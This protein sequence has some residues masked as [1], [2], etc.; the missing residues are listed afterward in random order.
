MKNSIGEKIPSWYR[1]DNSAKIYPAT[2]SK[3]RSNVFRL[4]VVLKEVVDPEVLSQALGTVIT[5]F[6]GFS[7]RIR[8]G[9]FWYYLEHNP[10]IPEVGLDTATP[11]IQMSWDENNGFLFRVLYYSRTISLECFHSIT[12]GVGGM[13][14]LKALCAQYLRFKGY[15]IEKDH[16]II[17]IDT[18][19]IMEEIQD[20]FLKYAKKGKLIFRKGKKAYRM[21]GTLESPGKHHI[22]T[23]ILRVD[24]V[25]AISR[26]MNVSVTE[27]LVGALIYVFY[28]HQKEHSETRS[29]PVTISVP[30]NLRNYFESQSLRNFTIS[31]SVGID[32][33]LGEYSFEEIVSQVH[34]YMRYSINSKF[35]MEQMSANVSA[36]RNRFVRITPLF[37]KNKCL[38]VALNVFHDSRI[39]SSL[40]NVGR[41]VVP[42][43][44]SEHIERFEAMSSPS[45]MKLVNC[46]VVSHKNTLVI[47][48]TR[49]IAESDIE[50]EFFRLLV[51]EGLH[52]KIESNDSQ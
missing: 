30:V 11:R 15:N 16:N 40:S 38:A 9:L 47:N 1:L 33:D 36:E 6:P 23:G 43:S 4:S 42:D 19:P 37:I 41:I 31:I 8:R 10:G 22:T 48:F 51:C 21:I 17:D 39:S 27:Y 49:A 18:L 25:L 12:D 20:S 45:R 50:M 5:R 28:K 14:F 46:V 13:E 24:E 2:R 3:T 32:T 29:K 52:V 26:A 35:L 7:V 34:Y 44:M